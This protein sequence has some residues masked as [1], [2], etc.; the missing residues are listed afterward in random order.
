MSGLVN[1]PGELLCEILKH[2]RPKD[3][4]NFLLSCK[5]LHGIASPKFVDN[6]TWLKLFLKTIDNAI[7][8]Y[9]TPKLLDLVGDD[10]CKADYV[11]AMV[12][13]P[14]RLQW[15]MANLPRHRLTGQ[16]PRSW[17]PYSSDRMRAFEQC[18]KN[19]KCIKSVEK[20]R[21][22]R[23]T[24]AGDETPLFALMFLR[25]H[26]LTSLVI[27]VTDLEDP[28]MLQTLQQIAKDPHSLSLSR[29][30]H[31]EIRRP[32]R[33][34]SL[35]RAQDVQYLLACAALPSIVSVEGYDLYEP[36]FIGVRE[37]P[38]NDEESSGVLCDPKS[39]QGAFELGSQTSR[40]QH[41]KV[42]GCMI[43][44]DTLGPLIRSARS[45]RSFTYVH[46]I[47]P[48][49]MR[50][51]QDVENVDPS[52]AWVREVLSESASTTLDKLVLDHSPC[53]HPRY[54]CGTELDFSNFIH[55]RTLIIAHSSL[56]GLNFRAV[57][58]ISTLLP[59]S[60]ETLVI[61]KFRI[62]SY[63]WLR[64]VVKQIAEAKVS[65]LPHLWELKFED[66]YSDATHF[67]DP[68]ALRSVYAIGA[69]VGIWTTAQFY[70]TGYEASLA[71]HG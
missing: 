4:D 1:L 55:L 8:S 6:H 51:R 37:E 24:R 23:Y 12:V 54:F 40:L 19:T 69:N 42:Q 10:P 14:W 30:R 52:H 71:V 57:D 67:F 21:W 63:V 48:H 16:V 61:R 17:Y 70:I 33:S 32:R 20:D 28:F 50:H 49:C 35:S 66:A 13:R 27:A 56:V 11:Q 34:R 43:L 64:L 5:R 62:E 29:L 44:R 59:A 26:H 46:C 47:R 7:S 65:S 38:S 39:A 15:D 60:L 45:L 31:V 22:I 9:T 3:I 36:L 2:V 18:I 53:P 68:Y 41:L 58:N 25:L